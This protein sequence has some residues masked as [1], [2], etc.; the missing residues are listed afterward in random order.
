MS[1]MA[2]HGVLV[3]GSELVV[4][5]QPTATG[6]RIRHAGELEF[7]PMEQRKERNALVAVSLVHQQTA[8]WA[9]TS[10][11]PTSQQEFSY[12]VWSINPSAC[13]CLE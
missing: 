9:T 4:P 12:S 6:V 7:V 10:V 3:V 2:T 1:R 11:C 8:Y 5:S 13:R